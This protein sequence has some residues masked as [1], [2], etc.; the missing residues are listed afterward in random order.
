MV[1][2]VCFHCGAEVLKLN[3]NLI[4]GSEFN[5]AVCSDPCS[6]WSGFLCVCVAHSHSE[7]LVN[8]LGPHF[9]LRRGSFFTER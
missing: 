3:L 6:L 2:A 8:N 4:C 5:W 7:I 9:L 1:V